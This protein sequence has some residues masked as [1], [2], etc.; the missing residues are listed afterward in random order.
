[1]S[2]D[3]LAWLERARLASSSRARAKYATSGLAQPGLETETQ[4]MLL[5]QLYLSHLQSGRFADALVAAE[6][7]LELDVLPDV[8]R[9][10]AA[11][12]C[13]AME[14]YD[15]ALEHLRL[16][17]RIAPASRR[18]LH[19]WTVGCLLYSI[20]RYSD[21]VGAFTRAARWGGSSKPLFLSQRALARLRA[22]EP[23]VQLERHRRQLFEAPCGQGYGQ[24]VLGELSFELG[25]YDDAR[26]FL[27]RFIDKSESGRTAMQVGLLLELRRAHELEQ[28]LPAGT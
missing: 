8:A 21:A 18:A 26:R 2:G 6:H 11:R 9:Q 14:A 17:G 15:E 4:A 3:A 7:M 5:R 1:M 10:D 23:G 25:Q 16:A 28:K 19:A 20:G 22:G 13:I 24:Y 27:R 12:A